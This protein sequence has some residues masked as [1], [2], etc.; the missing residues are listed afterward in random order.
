MTLWSEPARGFLLSDRRRPRA[1]RRVRADRARGRL[2]GPCAAA[3]CRPTFF[4]GAADI[5]VF[6]RGRLAYHLLAGVLLMFKRMWIT[7]LLVAAAP[8]AALACSVCGLAGTGD[9]NGAYRA[10]TVMMSGVPLGMIGGVA[11]WL[12]RRASKP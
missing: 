2:A 10:M 9:N 11:Y 8:A 1:A 6:R 7:A 3:R 4:L 5:L 12:V